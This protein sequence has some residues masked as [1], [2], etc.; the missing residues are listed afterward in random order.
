[1]EVSATKIQLMVVEKEFDQAM[2]SHAKGEKMNPIN[3]LPCAKVLVDTIISVGGSREKIY[4]LFNDKSEFA[5]VRGRK[6]FFARPSAPPNHDVTNV[7]VVL[8]SKTLEKER[9][10]SFVDTKIAQC[11]ESITDNAPVQERFEKIYRYH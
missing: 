3:I 9:K 7:N 4:F 5:Y 2:R 6:Q 1:M 10:S 11:C 8:R